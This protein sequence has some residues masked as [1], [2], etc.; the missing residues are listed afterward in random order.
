MSIYL[1]TKYHLNSFNMSFNVF[2]KDLLKNYYN[3]KQRKTGHTKTKKGLQGPG[4]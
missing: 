1:L 3:I 2:H 4:V